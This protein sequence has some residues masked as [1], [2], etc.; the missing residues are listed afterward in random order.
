MLT[1]TDLLGGEEDAKAAVELI[2]GELGVRAL[3]MSSATGVGVEDVLEACWQALAE[4][5]PQRP[6]WVD[7]PGRDKP[8]EA[9][10]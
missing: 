9:D 10:A 8:S 7:L 5:K 1:K 3:T 2:G 4:H 6:A